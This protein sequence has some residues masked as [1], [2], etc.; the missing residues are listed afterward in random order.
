M[1]TAAD[2]G[3]GGR[4]AWL[5]W[6]LGALLLLAAAVSWDLLR[7]RTGQAAQE[8]DSYADHL[9]VTGLEMSQSTS[10][11]GG[12]STFIDGHIQNNGPDTVTG[13]QLQ[14]AFANDEAMPAQVLTV[15]VTPIRTHE[16]YVDTQPLSEMPLKPGEDREF[17]L[18]FEQI[19]ATWNQ[20]VPGLHAEKVFLV[21][22]SAH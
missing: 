5:P 13:V 11:S 21:R 14:V 10:L 12:K 22:S 6:V 19:G 17:R 16:P 3:A 4:P 9:S 7:H 18:I 2:S 1:F 8:D 15:P 20:Q